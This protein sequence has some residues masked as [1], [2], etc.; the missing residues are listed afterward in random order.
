M[1]TYLLRRGS[2]GSSWVLMVKGAG[3][4]VFNFKI[5][6]SPKGFTVE[7]PDNPSP[8]TFLDIVAVVHYYKQHPDGVLGAL[9]QRPIAVLPFALSV[10][11]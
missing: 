1:G 7:H 10:D 5:L 6:A 11:L 9:P 4:Q 2:D 8:P 3:T